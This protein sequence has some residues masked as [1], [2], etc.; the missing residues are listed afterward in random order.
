MTALDTRTD[1]YLEQQVRDAYDELLDNY[2][3]C[4][5]ERLAVARATL[6]PCSHEAGYCATHRRNVARTF[7]WLAKAGQ[8]PP[9]G[10]CKT[11]V[12]AVAWGRL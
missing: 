5:C 3:C 6:L 4:M 7:A 2:E 11:T 8:L 1:A 9:C 10:F 12:E